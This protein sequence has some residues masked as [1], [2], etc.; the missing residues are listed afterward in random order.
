MHEPVGISGALA[1]VILDTLKK[2][3][4]TVAYPYDAYPDLLHISAFSRYY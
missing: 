4:C 1:G 3:A 2:R